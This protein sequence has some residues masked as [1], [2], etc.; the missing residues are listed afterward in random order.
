M[1]FAASDLGDVEQLA[2]AIGLVTDSGF[3]DDWLSRPGHYLSSILAED[4]QRE[5]L[6]EIVDELLGGSTRETDA[7]GQIWLPLFESQSPPVSFF[8]VVDDQPTDH[9]RIG[10]GFKVR[11]QSPE[12]AASLHLP[13]FMAARA[14]HSVANPILLGQAGGTID[15]TCDITVSTASPPPGEAHLRG[16]G[17]MLQVPT[18]GTAPDFGITVRGLRLPGATAQRDIT[19]SLANIDELDDIVLDLALGLLEAQARQAGGAVRAFTRL[20]GL[21]AGTLIPALPL[22]QLAQHGVK[23]MADWAVSVFRSAPAR[24]AWLGELAALLQN[25]ASVN[26]GR[27]ELPFGIGRVTLSVD[28]ADG[29]SG[30]PAI[31]PL[32]GIEASSGQAVARLEAKLFRLDLGT[33]NAVALPSLDAHG[34]FGRTLAGGTALLA[35]SDLAVDAIRFGLRLDQNRRPAATLALLNVR[36][37]THAPYPVLDLSSP[38]AVIEATGQV[39]GEVLDQVLGALGPV[40]ASLRTILGLS[41]PAGIPGLNA[42]DIATF[43]RDPLGAVRSYWRE[44]VLNHAGG[45]PLVLGPLRDLIADNSDIATAISGTGTPADPWTIVLVNPLELQAWKAADGNRLEL[46]LAAA[47]KNESLGLGCTRLDASLALGLLSIDLDGGPASFLTSVTADI[48]GRARGNR[49]AAIEVP[50]IGLTADSV[51]L[52][53]RWTPAA[54][55]KIGLNAAHP[56]VAVNGV[57]LPLDIPD[58]SAGFAGLSPTQWDA[59]EFIAGQLALMTPASWAVDSVDALGWLPSVPGAAAAHRLRLADLIADPQ[60]AILAW[61]KDVLLR[62][63]SRIEHL[64]APLARVLT[65]TNV[66][67]GQIDGS[68]RPQDPYRLPLSAIPGTPALTLWVEPDGPPLE[69]I[70]AVTQQLREWRPGEP[71]LSPGELTETISREAQAVP[72]IAAF[73]AGRAD[74][75]AGFGGLIERWTNT[76][77]RILA[78]SSDPPGVTMHL[79]DAA[80]NALATRFDLS[81]ALT[82]LPATII[83]VAVAASPADAPWTNAPANRIIDLTTPSLVPGAF[84]LPAATTGEWFVALGPR[85]VCRLAAGDVDGVAGQAARL[86]RILEPFRPLAGGLVLIAE[87]GAGHAARRAA[88]AIAEVTALVTLGTPAGPVAFSVLEAEPAASTLRLLNALIP[89]EIDEDPFDDDLALGR[90]LVRGLIM[91]ADAPALGDELAPPADPVPAPRAGLDV[92]AVFG[93]LTVADISRA[94][95]AIVAA[96]LS[97]RANSRAALPF[98][99]TGLGAGIHLPVSLGATGVTVRGH[100]ALEFFGADLTTPAIRDLRPLMVHLEIRRA[101]GWLVGG[102]GSNSGQDLRWLEFNLMLPLGGDG[103]STTE[104]ILHEPRIFDIRRDRWIVRQAGSTARGDEIVTSNLPEVGVLL[105][106]ALRELSRDADPEIAAALTLLEVAGV[107]ARSGTAGGFVASALDSILHQPGV[108]FRG[109][110]SAAATRPSLQ[111]ALN[112]ILAPISGLSLDLAQRRVDLSLSG[113]PGTIGLISWSLTASTT[114]G[115]TF[116]GELRLGEPGACLRLNLSPLTVTVEQPRLGQT[117]PAIIEAWPTPDISRLIGELPSILVASAI[118]IGL[119]ALRELDRTAKPLIDAVLDAL[120]FLTGTAGEETRQVRVPP[121]FLSNS[122]GY[123]TSS[124][125]FGAGSGALAST[126]AVAFLDALKTLLGLSGGS[127]EIHLANGATLAVSGI[128]GALRLGVTLDGAA[129]TTPPGNPPRLLFGGTIALDIAGNGTLRPAVDIFAGLPGAAAG[130]Q[131]AHL[132]VTDTVRLF[133]RPAAG[134]DIGLYPDPPG[135]GSIASAALQVLPFALDEVAKLTAPPAGATA[136]RIVGAIGDALDLR[137]ASKFDSAKLEAWAANPAQR[138]ADRLPLILQPL[139]GELATAIAPALPAGITIAAPANHLLLTAGPVALDFATSP[140]RVELQV[141]A[142]AVP[143]AGNIAATIAF[144]TTGLKSFTGMAGPAAIPVNGIDL[145]PFIAFAAGSN[146]LGGARLEA[147]AALDAA[148]SDRVFA[149]WN[150]T[151]GTFALVAKHAA[152]ESSDPEDVALALVRFALDLVARFAFAT[153]AVSDILET[154]VPN[155]TQPNTKIKTLFEGVFLLAGVNP[156]A[157]DPGLFDPDRL[158][159]RFM[160][161]LRNVGAAGPSIDVGGGIAIGARLDGN[162]VELTLGVNGRID[163]A[164]GDIG[165]ALEADSRWILGAPPAGLAIGFLDI[166]GADPVFK[167]SLLVNGIGLRVHRTSGPLLDS[168]FKLGSV[169]AHFYA[170]ISEAQFSG[171]V[172]LQLSELAV[173]AGG[174]GNAV[175]QGIMG[176]TGSGANALA[177]AFS[178]ALAV[179]K[180]GSGPVLVSLRAGEGDGPWWLSIQKSFGPLYVEQV[181]FGVTVRQDQLERISVLFDGRVSIAGL[182]AAVDDLQITFTVTSGTS[183]F[184]ASRWAVDLAGLAVSADIGGVTLSGG[185]RKF[186]SEPNIEYVGMLMA[187]VATYGLSIY[188]GYGTGVTDGARF[189]AFFAFGAVTGPIG[190]PPAFFVTGIGG[191]FGINRDLIFPESLQTFADF[192]MIKA[193]DPS[194]SASPDPMQELLKVRNT[195]PMRRDRFWLAAGLSFTSF[196]LVDGVAVVA[197]SFGGG[198]ELTLLGLARMALPRPQLRLVSIELGLIARFSTRDGVMWIQAELTENSWLLHESVRLTGGFAYV[199]W[200]AGEHAGEFVLTLGGYHP[201]FH[202]DGYPQVPRLGFRWQATP[203]ISVKGENYFALT[204]EALMAGGA[205]EASAKLGPAWANISF[206]ANVIIYFDPFR[207]EGDAHARIS[208]GVTIDLWLGEITIRVHLGARIVVAG[209]DFHGS[210]TFEIGPVD[211]TVRFGGSDKNRFEPISWDAFVTKYLEADSPGVARVLT[212]LPGKGAIAPGT[213]ANG[214]EKGTA[215][216]SPAKPFEVFSEFE[217]IVATIAPANRLIAGPETRDVAPSSILGLAPVGTASMSSVITLRLHPKGNPGDDR[218]GTLRLASTTAGSFPIGAW[219][220]VQPREDK[221]IPEGEVIDALNGALF[222]AEAQL[223]QTIPS[224]IDYNQVEA[225]P[226]HPLP[227]VTEKDD[228][229]RV[230]TGAKK[231]TDLL[232]PNPS[233]EKIYTTAAP[234]LADAGNTPVALAALK[235]DRA[236]PPRLGALGE[237]LAE[238]TPAKSVELTKA[239]PPKDVDHSVK[240]PRAIG[241]LAPL[242]RREV[243]LRRTSVKDKE[244]PRSLPPTMRE[245]DGMLTAGLPAKLLRVTARAGLSRGTLLANRGVP[246]TLQG[247]MA[248]AASTGRGVDAAALERLKALS[249]GLASLRATADSR[250][251]PGTV[252]ILAMPNARRDSGYA[253]RPSLQ[254]KGDARVAMLGAGGAILSDV[255]KESGAELI[256]QGTERI[257]VWASPSDPAATISGLAG[258]HAGQSLSYIGW[259]TCLCAG[260]SVYSEAAKMTR[261]PESFTTGWIAA[262]EFL[263]DSRLVTTRF[264]NPAQTLVIMLD[265]IAGEAADF[266]LSLRGTKIASDATGDEKSPILLSQGARRLLVYAL[267]PGDTGFTVEILREGAVA[268]AGIMASPASAA[269]T[270]AR[271]TEESAETLLDPPL[272]NPGDGVTLR[273]VQGRR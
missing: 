86:A 153:Q 30:F 250:I 233:A 196:A 178:P 189:S 232:P 180:H 71:G 105:S 41:V 152:A 239:D 15:F 198:F 209:P 155:T 57:A 164:T 247:R 219:G 21:S 3:N 17:L 273:F 60:A 222:V 16:V 254:F 50:P 227:F 224:E 56:A 218:I 160:Q 183:L 68:G 48:A 258:W 272:A 154:S 47:G 28:V 1:S 66:A 46:A 210:V 217:L 172:Q 177:P 188:G 114:A 111:A 129:L 104:V 216:G 42:T 238:Q 75:G 112:A 85:A 147:G 221:K 22:D 80:Y 231:L 211:L 67:L 13:L 265:E 24:D 140:F 79:V 5:A 99:V 117:T 187:R 118:R 138:F 207:Y 38:G 163:I 19:L 106:G 44:L 186:G 200:F 113:T 58:L 174:G 269:T 263:A 194:A 202:R 127:G 122:A 149:R 158:L 203:F 98:N 192:V 230:L 159:R 225:G 29:N 54:G 157:L 213:G 96:G 252:A 62:Q 14:G 262:K 31:T 11:S 237:R 34:L 133:I 88:Q 69:F 63:A 100:A 59:V 223:Q 4:D 199:M 162:L 10:L 94:L 144:D 87:G 43:L 76:D 121:A 35:T 61:A 128:S 135:L 126:K 77:G 101:D 6:L 148:G 136:A 53:A 208:A 206:A 170:D 139:L 23:A 9:I 72:E 212:S 125:A 191:G 270:A 179:Q 175:A 40:Q 83:H 249:A 226:R 205:L 220:P 120:G 25:G 95:T 74:L 92:H 108:H 242:A 20:I 228:R 93:R 193:I 109:L 78:P 36:F 12:A 181:G 234:W 185:L 251:A 256:P 241:I 165:V 143:F 97:T 161:L 51:G 26:A 7:R 115:G 169:A 132:A 266:S 55:L 264:T 214:E 259:S 137:T 102:P 130:R 253:R 267:M 243:K 248:P 271:L 182:V 156:P 268:V 166:G 184:D 27:V 195:F 141:K 145:R 255:T 124:A 90:D 168:V 204:S 245:A 52:T 39:I 49:P 81:E 235:G 107:Y 197:V 89:G 103:P 236:A 244:L 240:A 32:L 64:L 33:R 201:N 84:A 123:L 261:G 260:G 18:D 167:P 150:I 45:V 131:A 91:L 246:L 171:G 70:S 116:G 119:D 2:H 8:A 110:V 142:A 176:D 146:P 151:A 82:A 173:G 257:A 65:G 190:G 229:S 37:G 73:I 134:S 215:D